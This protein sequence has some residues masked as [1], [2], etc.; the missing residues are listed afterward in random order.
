MKEYSRDVF[1]RLD[2]ETRS[3][4]ARRLSG[5]LSAQMAGDSEFHRRVMDLVSALR[6]VGHDLWSYDEDDDFEVWGPSY[7][8]P[9]GPGLVI[10]FEPASVHAAW[11]V[12]RVSP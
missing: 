8:Q 7:V 11:S 2:D 4:L 6:D 5:F 12:E 10:R 1:V 9:S 3:E